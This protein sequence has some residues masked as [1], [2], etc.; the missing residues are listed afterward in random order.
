MPGKH[1]LDVS[2]YILTKGT[3][4]LW[5]KGVLM[6]GSLVSAVLVLVG[7]L[8]DFGWM[9]LNVDRGRVGLL[10]VLV[11]LGVGLSTLHSSALLMC[12]FVCGGGCK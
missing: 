7:R 10:E 5:A 8:L 3:G 4:Q 2:Q 6:A 12:G 11:E 9:L 1:G